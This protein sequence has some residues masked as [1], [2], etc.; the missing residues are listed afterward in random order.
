[1]S[2]NLH[3]CIFKA[4]DHVFFRILVTLLALMPVATAAQGPLTVDGAVKAALAHNASLRA[5]RARVDEAKAQTTQARS[6]YFPRI[7]IAESWQRGDQPVFVFSSLLSGRRFAA[8]NFAV[9]ALNH[10]DAVGFFRT[11]LALDQVVFDGGR[12]RLIT[13][14]ARL[15]QTIAETSTDEAAAALAVTTTQ[16]FGRVLL[17]DAARR[18][19]DTGLAAAREDLSRAEH[20]RDEG[21]ATDADVLALVVHVADLQQRTIRAEGEAATARAELNQLMGT[22]SMPLSASNHPA[23]RS[24][25]LVIVQAS[26]PSWRRLTLPGRRSNAPRPPSKLPKPRDNRPAP[27]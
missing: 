2:P 14:T 15:R 13:H 7:S 21:M 3:S 5:A 10:P 8:N 22:R 9:D 18:A 25:H 20:H 16:T 4:V 19:A 17:S 6:G 24:T 1:M 27:R 12:S 26:R 23:D 11:S